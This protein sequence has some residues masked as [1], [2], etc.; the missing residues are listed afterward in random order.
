MTR[1]VTAPR[2]VITVYRVALPPASVRLGG[3]P[4]GGPT[5]QF[6]GLQEPDDGQAAH[7]QHS[8][9]VGVPVLFQGSLGV[10]GVVKSSGGVSFV[11]G[12]GTASG[13]PGMTVCPT[14]TAPHH[15]RGGGVVLLG[16]TSKTI[17][18]L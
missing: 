3:A 6:I 9:I 1:P 15:A 5:G 18:R 13:N 12:S 8:C 14:A 17:L 7:A 2:M 11:A 10:V 16:A 4:H